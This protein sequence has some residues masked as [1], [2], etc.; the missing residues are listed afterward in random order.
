VSNH[1]GHED[2]SGRGTIEC[3]PEVLKALP[4]RC[5][6]SSTADSRGADV[7][8]AL[9][10]GATAVGIGRLPVRRTK[11]PRCEGRPIPTAVAPSASALKT[12]APPRNPL[13]M[14][15]HLTGSDFQDL[16]Q[17]LDCAPAAGVL[18]TAVVGHDNGINP[19]AEQQAP[20]PRASR[21]PKD[22]LHASGV[23]DAFHISQLS[24][25]LFS[26]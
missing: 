26:H 7:F 10:L 11:A 24:F 17:T 5:P 3:L 15:R 19:R 18:M 20:R 1:G 14:R 13:S 8:K 12:S 25:R 4:V 22:Q 9:A 2:A 21:C 16:R 6:S 23:P